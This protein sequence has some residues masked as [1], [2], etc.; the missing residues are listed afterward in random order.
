MRDESVRTVSGSGMTTDNAVSGSPTTDRVLRLFKFLRDVNRLRNRPERSLDQQVLAIP[1]TELPEHPTIQ[2]VRPVL[3]DEQLPI[4]FEL[5]V[6]RAKIT[7]CPQPPGVLKEWLISGWDDPS[8]LAEYAPSQN[9]INDQGETITIS[10]GDSPERLAVWDQWSEVRNA[11]SGPEKKARVAQQFFEKLYG[12]HAL[13]EKDGERLELIVGDGMLSWQ[14]H[15][16]TEASAVEILHPI[17]LK[18]VELI[19]D[20]A[21]PEFRVVDAGRDTELYT[22]LLIELEGLNAKGIAARQEELSAEGFHPLGYGDTQVFL[23]A[24][25]QTLSP[26]QGQFIDHVGTGFESYPRIWRQ[27]NLFVRRRIQSTATAISSIIDNIEQ[28]EQYPPAF[29]QIV[30]IPVVEHTNSVPEESPSLSAQ[31]AS[32]SIDDYE[33]LLAKETNNEQM[34]IIRQ[35]GKSGSVVVQGPPG[36]GKTHTIANVIGHLL[37]EG[38]TIL[39]TSHTPK[40]LRVLRDQ[41]PENLRDLCVSASG[42]DLESRRQLEASITA[43]SA[44]LA[45]ASVETLETQIQHRTKERR[46]LLEENQRLTATLRQALEGEY[47]NITIGE[48]SMA[49]ADAA[50]YVRLNESTCKWLPG[51]LEPSHAL[52]LSIQELAT[53]YSSNTEISMD[54]E[55]DVSFTLPP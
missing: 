13:L 35:L 34:Q 29:G 14:A 54:E 23:A 43:I 1:L 22:S 25:V 19:F 33:I 21:K 26:T 12:L 36:T 39:V 44:R 45:S 41:I 6:A 46:T 38:K 11:W 51:P 31:P 3:S 20:A 9:A 8:K 5:K 47:V 49:P 2:M 15:S 18:R 37:A 4:E 24:L 48:T 42:G 28:T 30:G 27:P 7:P 52:P 10:F 40:A 16:S 17:L 53:L 50:R 32:P 55:R